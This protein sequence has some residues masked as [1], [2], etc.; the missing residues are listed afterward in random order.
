MN[1]LLLEAQQSVNEML[2][3]G[4]L[5]TELVGELTL[6][7]L[8]ELAEEEAVLAIRAFIGAATEPG[9]DGSEA[10]IEMTREVAIKVSLIVARTIFALLGT[11]NGDSSDIVA[12]LPVSPDEVTAMMARLLAGGTATVQFYVPPS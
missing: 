12:Y 1:E 5:P 8:S 11:P 7:D 4:N 6:A 9:S 3:A 10:L 2:V